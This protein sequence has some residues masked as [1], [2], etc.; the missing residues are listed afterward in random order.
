MG[1][2][3][4][5]LKILQK[6]VGQSR[7]L[8]AGQSLALREIVMQ[9]WLADEPY[10]ADND[11]GFLGVQLGEVAGD[12]GEAGE[13]AGVLVV[14]RVVGFCGY[15]MLRNGDLILRVVDRPGFAV[16]SHAHLAA[17]IRTFPAGATVELELLRQGRV[18]GV[19][20]R[21]DARPLELREAMDLNNFQWRRVERFG[22]YWNRVFA[23]LLG[24]GVS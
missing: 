4:G 2:S 20:L 3:R 5:E 12:S 14:D 13:P 6:V 17:L 1:V 23:P 16:K 19:K 22:D 18:V 15:R 7:P 9:A 21:L 10:P 11:I 8:M 24:E